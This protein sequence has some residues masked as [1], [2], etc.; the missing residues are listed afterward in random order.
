VVNCTVCRDL[1][2]DSHASPDNKCSEERET[3]PN[4]P[5]VREVSNKLAKE[6]QQNASVLEIQ[7]EIEKWRKKRRKGACLVYFAREFL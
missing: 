3:R 7:L 2:A 6:Q 1:E 5:N 4:T